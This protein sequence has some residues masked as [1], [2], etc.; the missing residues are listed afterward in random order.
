MLIVANWK[1]YIEDLAKA[2][3]IFL[4]SRK[5][6]RETEHTIVL[7]PPGP[8]LGVFTEK[9]Q[10]EVM[11]AAQD[12]SATVGGAE[13][14]EATAAAYAAVGTAYAIIGHSERRARGDTD[15]IVAEKLVR[16]LA[17][18]LIPILCVGERERDGEG[19]Y[20]GSIREELTVA[21]SALLPNERAAVIVAYEPLWA[22]GKTAAES[23]SVNDL[24]EMILYIHKV[25]TEL[26]PGKSSAK[27][28]VLYGGS[29]E[30]GNVRMLADNSGV[31]G[32]LIGHA[33]ADAPTFAALVRELS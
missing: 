7:A 9:K 21:L 26:L 30:P 29:V 12:V 18:G 8:F 27:S 3:K 22:I 6:A 19:R 33:S 24:A 5:L 16:A 28:R 11:F 25:L 20:L 13:T 23:I 15:A 14:G 31:D 10:S 32:F 2:K 17:Q 4:V 1:A